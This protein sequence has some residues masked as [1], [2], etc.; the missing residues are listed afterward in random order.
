MNER[1]YGG[2]TGRSQGNT[3]TTK[4]NNANFSEKK[5]PKTE[6]SD[7]EVT[8]EYARDIKKA[9]EIAQKVKAYAKEIIKKDVK[10]LD[11]A[12]KIDAK[13]LELGGKTAFPVNLSINDIAAHYTPTYNDDST[14]KGLLKVDIGVHINGAIADTAFSLDLENSEENQKL[15][16]ASQNALNSALKIVKHGAKLNEIGKTI[17]TEIEGLGFSPIRNLCGHSLGEYLVHGGLTIPNYDNGNDAELDSG[18]YAIEPFA[19][20]GTG[21]VYEGKP[22]GIYQLLER[23][24]VRDSLARQIMDFIEEEYKTLPFAQRWIIKKFST[25]ALI[26]L[27]LMEKAGIIKQY[28]QLVEKSHEPVSQAEN[29]ILITDSNEVTVTT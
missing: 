2:E 8:E 29:T 18:A 24:A 9:G 14:A 17:Q 12:D 21:I 16:K 5:A 10:L 13:I 25:R 7:S 23:K 15:I 27:S 3:N 19:T 22:S 11:I 6:V 28:S 1:E 4:A 20:T 26:S